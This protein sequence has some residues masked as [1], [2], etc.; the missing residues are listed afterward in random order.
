MLVST[1]Y[2]L[3]FFLASSLG[4]PQLHRRGSSF[5]EKS[6]REIAESLAVMK[7]HGHARNRSSPENPPT[8]TLESPENRA[9]ETAQAVKQEA[10]ARRK[11]DPSANSASTPSKEL[12]HSMTSSASVISAKSDVT[13]SAEDDAETLVNEDAEKSRQTEAVEDWELR[14]RGDTLTPRERSESSTTL[15][16]E[17]E[18]LEVDEE[19]EDEVEEGVKEEGGYR[20]SVAFRQK[21]LDI[22]HLKTDSRIGL[23]VVKLADP[24]VDIVQLLGR[25]LPHVIPNVILAKREVSGYF[26]ANHFLGLHFCKNL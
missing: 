14:R 5:T 17:D 23:E 11:S 3:F 9:K 15:Q 2:Y 16:K 12:S 19:E 24:G 4:S 1:R 26:V 20:M 18:D 25:C 7:K 8:A 13:L 21:L 22:I 6:N 10:D